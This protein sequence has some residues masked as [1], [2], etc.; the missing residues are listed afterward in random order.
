MPEK[1]EPTVSCFFSG[2]AHRRGETPATISGPGVDIL[3]AVIPRMFAP[4]QKFK[5]AE[6]IVLAIAVRMM[7]AFA[8]GDSSPDMKFHDPHMLGQVASPARPWMVWIVGTDIPIAINLLSALP[9]G[10]R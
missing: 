6:I 5:V 1:S 8:R 10:M 9:S 2:I 3:G 4:R 7:D